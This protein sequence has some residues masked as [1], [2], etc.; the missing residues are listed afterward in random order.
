M[1]NLRES[2]KK[3]KILIYAFFQLFF[4]A[5]SRTLIGPLI[6]IISGELDIGLDFI[7]SAIA[8]SVFALFFALITTGNLIEI[9]GLKKVLIIG[10][11][12]NLIGSVLIYFSRSFLI[13]I[14]AFFFIEL[15]FGI[16]YVGNLSIVGT[17]YPSR[18]ASNLI[19]I[20]MGQVASLIFAPLIVGLIV[21]LNTNWR[22]Y[23]ILNLIFLLML[24]FL[25][26]RIKTPIHVKTENSIKKLFSDNKKI[27]TNPAFLIVAIIIFFYE[28][29]ME[30]F[31]VW[32]TS[33]FESINVDID[34]SS[35]FLTIYGTALLSGML[36]KNY[37]I[38]HFSEKKILLFSFVT[39]FFLLAGILFV[40]N[41]IMKNILIFLFGITV[42][43]NFTISFSVASTFLP[44][45]TNAASGLIFAFSNI[46]IIV[47]QFLTGYMS[48]YYSKSSVLYI[49]IVLMFILII[50]TS[51]LNYYRRFKRS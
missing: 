11:C 15:S 40:N 7:G 13:F 22:Y 35:L 25:L 38:K 9:I 50:I 17:L 29:I 12:I 49:N 41:L 33:Y 6:P 23:Y 18:R 42:V 37:L 27:I 4:F 45:Y 1:D 10:I 43:G 47:F 2:I 48:E 32:F 46:G 5:I 21:F 19:K 30:T 26:L 36:L 8:L 14:I 20:N 39:G 31:Y 16:I 51:F 44:K 28:P 24:L 3:N 34:I